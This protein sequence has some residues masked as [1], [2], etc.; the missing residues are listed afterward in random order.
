MKNTLRKIFLLT[1]TL[2]LTVICLAFSASAKTYGDFTYRIL[3]DCTI[4]ITAYN[5][6]ATA[7]EVPVKIKN[8]NVTSIGYSAFENNKTVKSVALPD[9][10]KKIGSNAFNNCTKLSKIN[11]PDSV[12]EIN[13]QAFSNCKR[14][15]KLS[16]PDSVTKIDSRAFENC[17]WYINQPDG[18]VYA[19]K[20]LYSYKGKMP[21]NT[22]LKTKS[23]TKAF[24]NYALQNQTNLVSLIIPDSITEIT[25]GVFSG[26]ENLRTVKLPKSLK[27][28]NSWAFHGCEKL[29]KIN[30]TGVERV[31]ENA[32]YNT[33]WYNGQPKG[34]VYIGKSL[35]KY[36]GTMPKNTS[37]KIKSGTK[38]ITWGA[39]RNCTGLKSVTFPDSLISIE[40]EVFYGCK[41]LQSVS[42]PKNLESIGPDVFYNC[43]KLKRVTVSDNVK[44]IGMGAFKNTA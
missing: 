3:P 2:I 6:K 12:T 34:V 36:K 31:G 44:T 42:L 37:I 8:T 39:F 17:A 10:I 20:V 26:C 24:A 14:L 32:F 11:I 38:Y 41:N 5:G 35:Y 23:G 9:T 16:I 15:K 25:Y 21:K 40:P 28:I 13:Y 22:S 1:A 27:R 19:G 4:E 43:T 33:A 7:V 30:L 18:F 29:S